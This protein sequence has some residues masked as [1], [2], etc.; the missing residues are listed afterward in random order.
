MEET[1]SAN[2]RS[3]VEVMMMDDSFRS[4]SLLPD[5]YYDTTEFS[6]VGKS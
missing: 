5:S 1:G 3:Q 4:S 2:V 6:S